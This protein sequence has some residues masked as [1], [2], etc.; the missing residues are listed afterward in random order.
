MATEQLA[1]SV[2][3]KSNLDAGIQRTISSSGNGSD[4]FSSLINTVS[5]GATDSPNEPEGLNNVPPFAPSGYGCE[6]IACG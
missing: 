3:G 2:G 5:A 1:E 4:I 6:V